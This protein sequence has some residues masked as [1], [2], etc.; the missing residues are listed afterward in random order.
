MYQPISPDVISELVNI[1]G[2]AYVLID[3]ENLEKYAHDETEDL[4][5]QS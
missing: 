5:Y 3:G 4:R 1:A 2:Q